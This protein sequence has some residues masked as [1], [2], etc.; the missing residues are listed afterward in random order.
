[1]AKEKEV[2]TSKLTTLKNNVVDAVV[3]VANLADVSARGISA[4]VLFFSTDS[5]TLHAVAAVLVISTAH[6]ALKLSMK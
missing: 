2:K 6:K 4:Y 5:L 3:G 1:M